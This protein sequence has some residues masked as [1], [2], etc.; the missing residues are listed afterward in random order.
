MRLCSTLFALLGGFALLHG[1]D[2]HPIDLRVSLMMAPET[3][4][5]DMTYRAGNSGISGETDSIDAGLRFQVGLVTRIARM[6]DTFTL[7]G[8]AWFFYSDQETDEV[9]PGEREIP[10]VTGPMEYTNMGVDFYVAVNARLNQYFEVEF[11]PFVGIGAT[12]YTD[13]GVKAGSPNG[14]VEES[15]SG[16]YEEAGLNLALLI[17]NASH[18]MFVSLGLQYLVS[19]GEADNAFDTVDEDGNRVVNG[20]KQHVEIDTRG[21]APYLA[22]G[23]TF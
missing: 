10:G 4:N 13:R 2:T 12:S 23:L 5:V 18:S 8:G 11:G 16:D 9:E 3:E 15:G 20:L 1:S 17:R 14:R 22:V 7:V 21:F 19:H 6:T